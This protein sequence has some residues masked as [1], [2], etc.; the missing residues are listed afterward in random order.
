MSALKQIKLDWFVRTHTAVCSMCSINAA[1]SEIT[2]TTRS[3]LTSTGPTGLFIDLFHTQ[4]SINGN[5][6]IQLNNPQEGTFFRAHT[7]SL[8][9]GYSDFRQYTLRNMS[10]KIPQSTFIATN[11]V[12]SQ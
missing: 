10:S 12:I 2:R 8:L 9:L 1:V 4:Y 6:N 7:L 3:A 11:P 5:G